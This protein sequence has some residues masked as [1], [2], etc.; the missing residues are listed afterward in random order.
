MNG[1]FTMPKFEQ[2][3]Q[4]FVE[5]AAEARSKSEFGFSELKMLAEQNR[6][7]RLG[8][9]TEFA[10]FALPQNEYVIAV[11]YIIE[12]RNAHESSLI[13]K[14]RFYVSRVLSTLFPHNFP[15]IYTSFGQHPNPDVKNITG[16][17]RQKIEGTS[18]HEPNEPNEPKKNNLL[19]FLMVKAG[20]WPKV[21]SEV[22]FPF[23]KAEKTLAREIGIYV[24]G[25]THGENFILGKDGGE[26]Y[27]DSPLSRPSSYPD[28]DTF[29]RDT[30]I[31]FMEKHDYSEHDIR[32]V[33]GALNRMD[34]LDKEWKQKQKNK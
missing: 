14:K 30:I 1:H 24:I 26:Y 17:V 15:K 23:K 21:R 8:S 27:I 32:R 18:P 20:L 33:S 4:K 2:G 13:A 16:S 28:T 6:L 11:S 3:Y 31:G 22:R 34:A 7:H 29:D 19:T 5:Q 10:V 25:D 12:G 9:G